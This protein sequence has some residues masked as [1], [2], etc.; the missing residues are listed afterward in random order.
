MPVDSIK[1]FPTILLQSTDILQNPVVLGI[2]AVALVLAIVLVIV[3]MQS[4]KAKRQHIQAAQRERAAYEFESRFGATFQRIPFHDNA[5]D[6]AK[7]IAQVFRDQL[8][9]SVVGIYAGRDGDEALLNVMTVTSPPTGALQGVPSSLPI[10]GLRGFA[11]PQITQLSSISPAHSTLSAP[12]AGEQAGAAAQAS[13]SQSPA[14]AVIP[15]HGSFGWKGLIVATISETTSFEALTHHRDALQSIGHRL[16]S[17]LEMSRSRT[18]QDSASRRVSST[19]AFA[20][21]VIRALDE[22]YPFT[23]IAKGIAALLGTDSAAVWRVDPDASMVRM[24]GQHGL[25]SA[26]FLPLPPGQGLAGSI[27][28]SKELLSIED[29]PSDPRCL[30]PREAKESGIA[31]Y[32]GMPLIDGDKLIAIIEVHSSTRRAWSSEDRRLLESAATIIVDVIKT[33]DARGNRLKVESSYLGLSEALQ[34]LRSESEV[35]EAAVEVLGHA[36]GVSRAIIV[37]VNDHGHVEQVKHEYRTPTTSS[38]MGAALGDEIF[39]KENLPSRDPIAIN[40][41]SER[42]LVSSEVRT[43]LS[44]LSELAVPIKLNGDDRVLLYLNQCDRVREW[45]PEEIAFTD[46][47]ARQLSLSLSN[48]RALERASRDADEAKSETRQLIEESAQTESFI[49]ALPEAV[50]GLDKEGRVT[51]FNTAGRSWLG[52][53]DDDIGRMADMT[54]PLALSD[55]SIWEA[56]SAA[57]GPT[58]FEARLTHLTSSDSD[59]GALDTTQG[60]VQ[61]PVSISVAPVRNARGE[62]AGRVVVMS[63]ISHVG[64]SP[65]KAPAN[66]S[67][68][69]D[70]MVE[71]ERAVTLLREAE[72]DA[73]S[74]LEQAQAAE[75]QAKV[76]AESWQRSESEVREELDPRPSG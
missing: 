42:S 46:R 72:A 57:K 48:A 49:H 71:L 23:G 65:T 43:N 17:A 39:S 30:F 5:A 68:M 40:I 58:R 52:L 19:I 18:G 20:G 33:T 12:Q 53:K 59:T 24:V 7:S 11:Q 3:L 73:R 61:L 16:A 31:S 44:I 62:I 37:E 8:G 14:A 47:V 64:T 6:A 34:R 75:A 63:D 51:F 50:L 60:A 74:A 54:E 36:L 13:L 21:E 22:Q 35:M 70:R 25:R 4:G 28:A 29:A 32:L 76:I 45:K 26:E 41:S 2:G 66:I 56:V 27:L 69:R 9:M 15:W 55:D 10:S 38:A 67:E 1:L